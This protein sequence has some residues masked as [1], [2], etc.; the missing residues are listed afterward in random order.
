MSR[1]RDLRDE[2][3]PLQLRRIQERVREARLNLELRGAFW[4]L[5]SLMWEGGG[6]IQDD[7]RWL[8]GQA[9]CSTRR[10]NATVEMLKERELIAVGDGFI[11]DVATSGAII[12]HNAY[13]ARQG[14]SGR[15]GG[16][17][18][19][20]NRAIQA[21]KDGRRQKQ[22]M[23]EKVEI[24]ASKDLASLPVQPV[25]S[26]GLAYSSAKFAP[27]CQSTIKNRS[28]LLRGKCSDPT[29]RCAVPLGGGARVGQGPDNNGLPDYNDLRN[30]HAANV[31]AVERAVSD[32]EVAEALRRYQETATELRDRRGKH[33]EGGG[34]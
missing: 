29:P 10:W 30:R 3:F 34:R 21:D 18:K 9:G 15:R 4:L 32:E 22:G 16:D 2:Y 6:P 23:R 5:I 12:A 11:V 7:A 24:I 17:A 31:V 8:A 14:E 1:R 27:N 33:P 25:N 19:S 26:L 13:R 20:R 28:L